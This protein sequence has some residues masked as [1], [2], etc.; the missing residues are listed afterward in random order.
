M[1]ALLAG[2]VRPDGPCVTI[3]TDGN[4][5]MA[6]HPRVASGEDADPMHDARQAEDA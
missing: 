4:V 3:L 1:A 5:D 6:L 2:K